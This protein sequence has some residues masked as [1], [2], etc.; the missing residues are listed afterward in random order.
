MT[1]RTRLIVMSLTAPVVAFAVVGGFL[2][3]VNAREDTYQQLKMFDDVAGLISNNY[4]EQ[5]NLDKVM[6]GAMRGLVES[7]DPDSSYLTPPEVKQAES[8]AALPAGDVGLDLTRQYYLRVV[9]ARDN[10]PA[11]KAGLRTGDYVRMID[12]M[13]TR[14]MSVWEGMRAL[15]GTPGS[16]VKLTIIR[17]NAVEP[18]LVELK[19]EAVTGAD[20]TGRMAATGVGYL[21]VVQIGPKTPEL[22]AARIAELRKTGAT[23]L[24]VD[25]RRT[26]GGPLDA[27]VA[28]ARLFVPKG[29][30]AVREAKGA[31]HESI[32]AKPG[33]GTVTLP[34][35]LLIDAGTSGAAELFASA[36]L[37]NQRAELVGERTMGRTA[38][39]RLIKLPDGSGLWLS[40][41][42]YLTPS[43]NP[44][45]ER[46]L[47]PTVI[48][49]EPEVEFGQ[50]P[51][52]TDPILEKAIERA[53]TR[54]AA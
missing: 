46:G 19:R 28:L 47:E 24:I 15:R 49:D 6:K 52:A 17:G 18:H 34:V 26:A 12:D 41:S 13:P 48:V 10:S 21:R 3:K 33:D 42:R 53:T 51:P 39:Q 23:Q 2:G 16:S 31:E 32:T 35:T 25:V 11:A 1:A 29:V 45:H 22:V 37:G 4:V 40:T 30:I 5:V 38:V 44:L 43:G 36:L 54:K 20:V 27:G 9:A 14:D 7:L 50:P 8:G